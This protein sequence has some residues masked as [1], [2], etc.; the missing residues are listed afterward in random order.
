MGRRLGALDAENRRNNYRRLKPS[1]SPSHILPM[2]KRLILSALTFCVAFVSTQ[3]LLAQGSSGEKPELI[4]YRHNGGLGGSTPVEMGDTLGTIWFKGLTATKNAPAGAAIR[5]VITGPVSPGFM[6]SNLLFRTGVPTLHDRMV[7]TSTGLV[8]I[9]TTDPQYHL[10]IVGNTHTSGDFFGRIHADN[11]PGDEAPNTYIN[12]AYFEYKNRSVL[13]VPVAAGGGTHG[14]LF[15]FAPGAFSN[16]HQLFFGDD[17]LYHRRTDANAASWAG[18][19]WYK[20]LTGEDING[21]TNYVSKF[22]S[23]TTLGDSQ[24][25][26]NGASVGIGTN[27]PGAKLAVNGD[28]RAA[29][30]ATVG[31]NLVVGNS[32]SVQTTA[33]LQGATHVGGT[34]DVTGLA[35]FNNGAFAGNGGVPG[36]DALNVT[37]PARLNGQVAISTAAGLPAMAAGFALSVE[38]KIMADEVQVSLRTEWPDYVFAPDYQLPNLRETEAFIQANQHLPGIPS[39]A[40]IQAQGG[41]ALG[42]MNRLLLEKVEELTLLLIEQQ[43]QI[44]ALQQEVRGEK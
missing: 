24:I 2:K 23:P 13:N 42:E 11:N 38:G 3:S 28:F 18:S 33:D 19:T 34:L 16:D 36:Q 31:Q 37:G 14:G 40:E 17:G 39:A 22:T 43:K 25:F 5:S 9:G 30:N 27:T 7:I 8:G 21:T 35:S 20:L 6:P 44:D 29:T 15:S 32:L 1:F 26:D 4:L 41:V 10:D 12:E